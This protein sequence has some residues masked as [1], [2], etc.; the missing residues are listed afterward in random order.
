MSGE[1]KGPGDLRDE[2]WREY[3]W[4]MDNGQLRIYRINDP[5]DLYYRPGGTTHR[6]VDM[7]GIIHCVPTVG[8]MGC[9]LRWTKREGTQDVAF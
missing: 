6:V 2:L 8:H 9:V 3:E 4:V 7:G 5:K 1:L